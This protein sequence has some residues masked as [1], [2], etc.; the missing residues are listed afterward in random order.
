MVSVNILVCFNKANNIDKILVLLN[1]IYETRLIHEVDKMECT[2]KFYAYWEEKFF[3]DSEN[4]FNGVEALL[5]EPPFDEITLADGFWDY[6]NEKMNMMFDYA[7]EEL[8]SYHVI[9][10]LINNIR[11]NCTS[12]YNHTGEYSKIV[13]QQLPPNTEKVI[14]ITTYQEIRRNLDI[15]CEFLMN[16]F[17]NKKDIVIML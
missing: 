1:F 7:E 3:D 14:A 13:A 8:I 9:P 5:I 2:R 15:L 6:I 16:A 11:T 17:K 10:E 12:R 4:N